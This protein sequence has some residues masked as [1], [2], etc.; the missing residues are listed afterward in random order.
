MIQNEGKHSV[1]SMFMFFSKISG[2]MIHHFQ[3][4]LYMVSKMRCWCENFELWAFR[5]QGSMACILK[6]GASS[7]WWSSQYS[8]VR[9]SGHVTIGKTHPHFTKLTL[10]GRKL[11]YSKYLFE[12][13]TLIVQD[14]FII[15]LVSSVLN[16][17]AL[18]EYL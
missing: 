17:N 8:P 14:V 12:T 13:I 5:L 4:R 15:I 18:Y 6:W 11:Y 1:P 9:N 3:D 2:R 10:Y 16:V 7:W